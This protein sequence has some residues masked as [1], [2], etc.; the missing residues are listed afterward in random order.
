MRRRD[1]DQHLRD[2][3]VDRIVILVAGFLEIDREDGRLRATAR[4]H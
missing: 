4:V 2:Y 3:A 1:L